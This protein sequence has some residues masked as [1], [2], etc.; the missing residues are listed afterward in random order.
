MKFFKSWY[1]L[2]IIFLSNKKSQSSI[3][4]TYQAH[5]TEKEKSE[6]NECGNRLFGKL[7]IYKCD[8]LLL[9]GFYNNCAK[10]VWDIMCFSVF[11]DLY[12]AAPERRDT[13]EHS[14]EAKAFYDHDYV[15]FQRVYGLSFIKN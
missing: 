4:F 9:L 7:C 6:S 2:K 13:C 10:V 12:C 15:S 3:S 11:W 1:T 14:S 5:V 8:R